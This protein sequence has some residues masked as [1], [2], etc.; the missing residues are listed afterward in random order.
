MPGATSSAVYAVTFDRGA[1]LVARVFT[2]TE[3]LAKEPDLAEHEAAALEFLGPIDLP[4]PGLVAVDATGVAAGSPA[5]LMDLLPGIVDL[6]PYP[7]DVWLAAL[8]A[9][10]SVL[11][12]V[13][14]YDFPWRYDPWIDVES[15]RPPTWA[16]DPALWEEAIDRY[17]AGMPDE[18]PR[19]LHRDY[20]PTNILWAEGKIT[21]IVDWVNACV[22]PASADVAHCRLNLALMSGRDA[23]ERF[24][25]LLDRPYDPGWDLAPALS[26]L[27][28][29]DVYPPWHAFG[30]TG[31]TLPLI[32]SRIE[33]FVRRA[34]SP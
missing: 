31:L 30:L 22:G 27:P 25:G 17:G 1:P 28:S 7:T 4:S 21:G 12:S 13:E 9:P 34:L 33:E 24:T 15:L 29:F 16:D 14:P 26:V 6:P 8:A 32:R 2:N 5:V 19:F 20:H 11:H 3:W 10:L 23:A 18:E